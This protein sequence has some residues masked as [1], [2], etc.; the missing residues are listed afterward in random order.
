VKV[1]VTRGRNG[2]TG[3]PLG[4]AL[5]SSLPSGG[6]P[7]YPESNCQEPGFEFHT[8]FF[9]FFCFSIRDES[10]FLEEGGI[11]ALAHR[12]PR[13]PCSGLLLGNGHP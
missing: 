5:R 2:W 6:H 9:L 13:S 4:G 3:Q 12:S 8:A 7:L 1:T 11:T 10:S